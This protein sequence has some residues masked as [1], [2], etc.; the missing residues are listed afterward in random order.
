MGVFCWLSCVTY[1]AF[2]IV[3]PI[4]NSLKKSIVLFNV[5]ISSLLATLPVAY[6]EMSLLMLMI[7]S[8]SLVLP[9]L[10][11]AF[12]F[13]VVLL[14]LELFREF[15]LYL[16]FRDFLPTDLVESAAAPFLLYL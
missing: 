1:Y 4:Y 8:G 16:E 10:F 3:E 13:G 12:D 6:D 5:F 9:R 14:C 2:L 11:D 15:D 7:F